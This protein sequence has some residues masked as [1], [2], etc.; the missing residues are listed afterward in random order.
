MF[1]LAINV[2]LGQGT[3]EGEGVPFADSQQDSQRQPQR[4]GEFLATATGSVAAGA[5]DQ[6]PPMSELQVAS[7]L[8]VSLQTEPWSLFRTINIVEPAIL[9]AAPRKLGQVRATLFSFSSQF[10]L[11][12]PET[13]GEISKI[14]N[15]HGLAFW[16]V[17]QDIYDCQDRLLGTLAFTTDFLSILE[18][19]FTYKYVQR[20]V[21]DSQ[22]THIANVV[23]ETLTEDKNLYFGSLQHF[24][25]LEDLSGNPMV[26]MRHP[27]G[28]WDIPGVF[29]ESFDVQIQYLALNPSV[30]PPAMNPEFLSLIFANALAGQSRLG[31]YVACIVWPI[32]ILIFGGCFAVYFLPALFRCLCC[33]LSCVSCG[34]IG[35][36]HN[37]A[38]SPTEEKLFSFVGGGGSGG[39]GAAA[40]HSPLEEKEALIEKKG[41]ELQRDFW[42]CCSR[43]GR[44][45]APGANKPT[46]AGH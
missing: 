12:H 41:E 34:F 31:P 35:R 24:V 7:P 39:T 2:C 38:A 25:Y 43:A 21:L 44:T 33:T 28:G 45:V 1:A 36:A 11:H 6:C 26:G 10:S 40:A 9:G 3:W 8:T 13:D 46:A 5:V 22:G 18:N 32:L 19:L 17:G 30:A 14:V 42:S 23:H 4:Q 20:K 27:S 29:G 15:P 37:A 16:D